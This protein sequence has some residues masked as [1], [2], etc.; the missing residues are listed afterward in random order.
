MKKDL[1]LL[2]YIKPGVSAVKS[3]QYAF[4]EKLSPVRQALNASTIETIEDYVPIAKGLVSVRYKDNDGDWQNHFLG[5]PNLLVQG[6]RKMLTH[7][8]A[9]FDT[10]NDSIDYR[11]KWFQLGTKGHDTD[12]TIPVSPTIADSQLNAGTAPPGGTPSGSEQLFEKEIHENVLTNGTT[13]VFD[14]NPP[15][16][17]SALRLIIPIDSGEAN[18][19]GTVAWTEAG[20]FS[21]SGIM[22]SRVT[23]PAIIKTS[24]RTVIF[25]WIL[26][27]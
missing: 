25:E 26:V 24:G 22:F 6:S 27:F 10:H 7:V 12:I 1:N 11:V 13:F 14:G 19:G 9:P 18:G 4:Y 17:E 8:I 16:N 23:F 21:N 15:S 3:A 20:L 2:R 5:R